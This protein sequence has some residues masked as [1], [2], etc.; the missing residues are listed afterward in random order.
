MP[1]DRN[2]DALR[3]ESERLRIDFIQ[4]DL[5]VCETFIALGRTEFELGDMSRV[6]EVLEKVHVATETIANFIGK[7]ISTEDR[8]RFIGQLTKLKVATEELE[9]L[10]K[11]PN[12]AIV[13]NNDAEES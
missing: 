7:L 5:E 4:R 12:L 10:V 11:N 8:A 2:F 13:G 1:N 9:A 6:N 3:R